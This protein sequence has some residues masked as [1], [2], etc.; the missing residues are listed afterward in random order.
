M[1]F[2]QFFD[3]ST[4]NKVLSYG[5]QANLKLSALGDEKYY[6]IYDDSQLREI[7]Y[8]ILNSTA[9]FKYFFFRSETTEDYTNKLRNMMQ[10]PKVI[11]LLSDKTGLDLREVTTCFV[12]KYSEGCFLNEHFDGCKGQCAFMLYLNDVNEE[13]G[14][15]LVIDK[16]YKIQPKA[17][18]LVLLKTSILHKVTPVV[19]NERWT[20][21]GWLA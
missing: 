8:K 2:D 17:N 11:Q 6:G 16:Q 19:R 14:G 3:S 20:F 18:R 15:M 1:I 21:T 7:N 5:K 9:P 13:D 10:Y 4:F 12:S